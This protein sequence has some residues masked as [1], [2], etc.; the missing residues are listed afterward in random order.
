MDRIFISYR[1]EDSA[2]VTGRI[3]A[4]LAKTFGPQRVLMDIHEDRQRSDLRQAVEAALDR[5]A[6]AIAVIGND[7]ISSRHGSWPRMGQR[8]IDDETDIVRIELETALTRGV[9]VIPVLVERAPL[10]EPS[11]LPMPLG[12]ML[13]RPPAE[14]RPGDELGPS[15]KKL[16][17]YV[18][19]LLPANGTGA[20]TA[21]SASSPEDVI[22][23][24]VE[25]TQLRDQP[26]TLVGRSLGP[27]TVTEFLSITRTGWLYKARS[28]RT[29]PVFFKVVF[30]VD[31]EAEAV[32]RTVMRTHRAIAAL[33]HPPL[34]AIVETHPVRLRDGLTF[35]FAIERSEGDTLDEWS[36][37]LPTSG[38]ARAARL[39]VAHRVAVALRVAH[40]AVHLGPG[41]KPVTGIPHGDLQP[42]TIRVS[43]DGRPTVLDFPLSGVHARLRVPDEAGGWA[44]F[45]WSAFR[46]PE[47][48]RSTPAT[49]SGDIA[50]YG[51]TLRA[52][53]LGE[54]PEVDRLL[55]RM[56][57]LD[58][59]ARPASMA[60]VAEALE[61]L[62]AEAA[63]GSPLLGHP[64]LASRLEQASPRESSSA[65]ADG[66]AG[67]RPVVNDSSAPQ[68]AP[69]RAPS[70]PFDRAG[71]PFGPVGEPFGP[72]GEPFG[73]VGEP[74]GP[75][76]EPFEV[77]P[78]VLAEPSVRVVD[79]PP[80]VDPVAE[81]RD[82]TEPPN[83]P[84]P[85]DA[86]REAAPHDTFLDVR[87]EDVQRRESAQE[88]LAGRRPAASNFNLAAHDTVM[89]V[90]PRDGWHTDDASEV[91]LAGD[92]EAQE[93][94]EVDEVT[95]VNVAP[96]DLSRQA[97]PTR[98]VDVYDP[99]VD[100]T[101]LDARNIVPPPD[102]VT[103]T[104]HRV[105]GAVPSEPT[106]P[107]VE[108]TVDSPTVRT[109]VDPALL[110]R[111]ALTT[112]ERNPKTL[113]SIAEDPGS[114]PR[115]TPAVSLGFES[116]DGDWLTPEPGPP[117]P[118]LADDLSVP[119]PAVPAPKAPAVPAPKAPAP[120]AATSAERPDPAVD[121]QV[122]LP[123]FP[124]FD[125]PSA[126]AEAPANVA[127]E[128]IDPWE[129]GPRPPLPIDP[130]LD[131]EQFSARE[132][133]PVSE[134]AEPDSSDQADE[135]RGF[136]GRIKGWFS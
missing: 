12:A 41:G 7:W 47:L 108:A 104:D 88:R 84:S 121:L 111:S 135:K 33:D 18:E 110:L 36:A 3:Y 82:E 61:V 85:N 9:P 8:R 46:A 29:G 34:A 86:P 76:G 38:L 4:H 92:A 95:L 6:V 15:L 16:Q 65:V 131:Q 68:A 58:P 118:G 125:D 19:G 122:D 43:R 120:A 127:P 59:S 66:S 5:V 17:S 80:P 128:A 129:A 37:G 87:V 105:L 97:E 62:A 39:R 40:E 57:A 112:G 49:M 64:S 126:G 60:E 51:V 132:G 117:P 106:P 27:F 72:V 70:D 91:E 100:A 98:P 20:V 99:D 11:E 14:V 75:V 24:D 123:S 53:G 1:R 28:P 31:D 44:P 73:P 94:Q 101:L 93:A 56:T 71:E 130:Q 30:P 77:A 22:V 69:I 107:V 89:D 119:L 133:E 32:R 55:D 25:L 52:I 21:A 81:A 102:D 45:K 109:R 115:K 2:E 54:H 113:E 90:V 96:F 48:D 103:R 134:G 63:D 35:V 116:E 13:H 50:S 124:K 23:A 26:T 136:F 10:P 67:I 42:D 79:A 114:K 78:A 74:F 83:T